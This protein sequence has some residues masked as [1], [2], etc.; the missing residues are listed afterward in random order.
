MYHSHEDIFIWYKENVVLSCMSAD[1]KPL[2]CSQ[3]GYSKLWPPQLPLENAWDR[4][5]RLPNINKSKGDRVI[6]KDIKLAIIA[7]LPG[8]EACTII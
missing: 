2:T 3:A 4:S 6:Q 8:F 7:S 5:K 1:P